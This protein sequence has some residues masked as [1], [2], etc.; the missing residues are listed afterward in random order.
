MPIAQQCAALWEHAGQINTIAFSK[1]LRVAATDMLNNF[2]FVD[3]YKE[4][5]R[6]NEKLYMTVQTEHSTE[7]HQL[8]ENQMMDIGFVYSL[9]HFPNVNAKPLFRED[10]VLLFHVDSKFAKTKNINDLDL[11]N[12]LYSILP[13]EYEHWHK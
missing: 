2:L 11:N 8:I 13:G 7:I 6:T 5:L 10:M 3:I 12:E 4:F 9:H 1:K